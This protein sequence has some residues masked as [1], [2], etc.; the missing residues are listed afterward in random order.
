MSVRARRWVWP[1][2]D[3]RWW[4]L[5]MLQGAMKLGALSQIRIAS[6][7]GWAPRMAITRFRL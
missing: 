7:R 6:I 1:G 3:F 2:A 5:A 4:D